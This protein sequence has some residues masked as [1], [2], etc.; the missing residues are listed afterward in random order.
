M[1]GA[2]TQLTDSQ[3]LPQISPSTPKPVAESK[4]CQSLAANC[5]KI[6]DP[7][8]ELVLC[9]EKDADPEKLKFL[10]LSA[11]NLA[12]E[13]VH[14]QSQVQSQPSGVNVKTLAGIFAGTETLIK[15]VEE[16][17]K[18]T[19]AV[20]DPSDSEGFGEAPLLGKVSRTRR[21]K[22]A[23]LRNSSAKSKTSDKRKLFIDSDSS[24]A[25]TIEI[26]PGIENQGFINATETAVL[27]SG[28]ELEVLDVITIREPDISSSLSE[29]V[30]IHGIGSGADAESA[31]VKPKSKKKKRPTTGKTNRVAPTMDQRQCK[32]AKNKEEC[33]DSDELTSPDP[34]EPW[35]T[36]SIANMN[37]ILAWQNE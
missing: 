3:C 15:K 7:L 18:K 6:E 5:P 25:D 34:L 8:R 17:L 14:N 32:S 33:E 29:T 10:A 21:S 9:D 31:N 4:F 12:K 16:N 2:L 30:N 28:L 26:M 36:K 35:S 11:A 22:S 27:Q 1:M 20:L 23:H 24:T 13:E 19:L 37:S